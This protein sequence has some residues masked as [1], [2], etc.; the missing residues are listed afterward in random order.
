MEE[1]KCSTFT[2]ETFRGYQ[3]EKKKNYSAIDL[4]IK[5]D[6]F[7]L[8]KSLKKNKGRHL[9]SGESERRNTALK[10]RMR[11]LIC[12]LKSIAQKTGNMQ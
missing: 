7:I 5:T 10:T 1:Q 4:C 2:E 11:K 6:N 3:L 12:K 8:T 9:Y